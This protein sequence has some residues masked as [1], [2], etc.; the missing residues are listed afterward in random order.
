MGIDNP[1]NREEKR[2]LEEEKISYKKE[3]DFYENFE[4]KN[5][6]F[7]VSKFA[8]EEFMEQAKKYLEEVLENITPEQLVYGE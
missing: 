3:L 8:D 6:S 2:K 1:E 7:K 4:L 5:N